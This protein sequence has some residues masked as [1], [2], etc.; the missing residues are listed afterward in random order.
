MGMLIVQSY[1]RIRRAIIL[2]LA[3]LKARINDFVDVV[4]DRI[5]VFLCRHYERSMG[6]HSYGYQG[7]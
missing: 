5:V 2:A 4:L 1:L 7:D 6:H 3:F